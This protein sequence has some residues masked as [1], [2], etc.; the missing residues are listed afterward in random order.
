MSKFYNIPL[1]E[2][3]HEFLL[4][5]SRRDKTSMKKLISEALEEKY[6]KDELYNMLKD[7]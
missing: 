5:K 2:R 6:G 1:D 7:S 3:M 4:L